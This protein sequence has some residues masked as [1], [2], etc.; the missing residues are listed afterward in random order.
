MGE[1]SLRTGAE[2]GSGGVQGSLSTGLGA[3]WARRRC[4]AG[5]AG[6]G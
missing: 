3:T 4:S 5:Q 2:R 6:A 1:R